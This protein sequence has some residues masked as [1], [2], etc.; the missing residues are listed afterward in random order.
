MRPP[1][2]SF[3]CAFGR[4]MYLQIKPESEGTIYRTMVST[5]TFASAVDAGYACGNPNINHD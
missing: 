3:P 5:D 2:S 1:L 4:L